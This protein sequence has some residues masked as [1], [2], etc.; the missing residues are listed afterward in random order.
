MALLKKNRKRADTKPVAKT[1]LFGI[2]FLIISILNFIYL[3]TKIDKKGKTKLTQN[4]LNY[5][6]HKLAEE[7]FRNEIIE[8]QL[9]NFKQEL[10]FFLPKEILKPKKNEQK[11][12]LRTIASLVTKPEN[13]KLKSQITKHLFLEAKREFNNKNFKTSIQKL[14]HLIKNHPLSIYTIE[15]YYLLMES[16][17]SL[18]NIKEC[19]KISKKMMKFFPESEFTGSALLRI[20]EIYAKEKNFEKALEVY[21][22]TLHSFSNKKLQAKAKNLIHK[23]KKISL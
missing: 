2:T 18:N 13:R 14:T 23:I 20:G 10:A 6:Q 16:E 1:T 12:K 3:Q 8:N 9:L 5:F 19:I 15:A 17:F 21:E 22:T 11:N 7:R 4:T